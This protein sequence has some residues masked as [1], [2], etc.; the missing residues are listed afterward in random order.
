M[1]KSILE[2]LDYIVPRFLDEEV[3][4]IEQDDGYHLCKPL[5]LV[6]DGEIYDGIVT[7]RVFNFFGKAYAPNVVSEVREFKRK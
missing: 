4:V 3:V 7:V 6:E 5:R 1:I 2:F